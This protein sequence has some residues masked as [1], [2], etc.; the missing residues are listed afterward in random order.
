M[1][2]KAMF[3]T[4]VIVTASTKGADSRCEVEVEASIGDGTN[5]DSES[6]LGRDPFK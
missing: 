2:T 6:G 1:V 3:I 4:Q 5:I